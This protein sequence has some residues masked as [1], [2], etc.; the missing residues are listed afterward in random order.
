MRKTYFISDLHLSD[1]HP[2][3]TQAFFDFLAKHMNADVDALYILGDF[4]EVWIGDDEQS[5]LAIS[6]ANKLK[7]VSQ[8]GIN[9]FFVHGNRDFLLSK[10]YAKQAGFKLLPEQHI[11]DL[12]GTPTLVLHGD[13]MC[14]QDIA[15]QKFRKKSRG[16]WWPRLI[17]SL[18]LSVRRNI[19]R[20]GRAKSKA[21]QMGKAA[22]ILDVTSSAVIE[23]FERYN[24][25]HMIHGHTHRPNV[26]AYEH[27]NKKL[28][29]T[30]LGDWYSQ[31]SY[32]VVN[33]AGEHTLI[34]DKTAQ[35]SE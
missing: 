14:T 28:T 17:L 18:P 10:R 8:T 30:V 34:K 5:P 13:E 20:N 35:S 26:H 19:A 16:W 15:Y 24:V 32:L 9:I 12:Y 2:Q 23:M 11:V 31:S 6:V 3:I 4:F 22:A 21:N 1:D 33:E 29:R 27:N 25:E 7:A